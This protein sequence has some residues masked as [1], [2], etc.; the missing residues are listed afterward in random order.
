MREIQHKNNSSVLGDV[1]VLTPVSLSMRENATFEEWTAA[2]EHLR[3][4]ESGILWWIGDWWHYGDHKYGERK[5]Q[6]FDPESDRNRFQT[7]ADAGWVSGKIETSRRH[8]VLSW[9]HHREVAA[10][11]PPEQDEWLDRAEGEGWT[12]QELRR[13]VKDS[14]RGIIREQQA[15]EAKL[16]S[17]YSVVYADPPWSYSNS[18]FEGGAE[19]HYPT[20][21]TD[22]IAEMP[23]QDFLT[24]DAVLFMW[25]TNPLLED[26]IRVIERWDF[27]YKTNFVWV[28]DRGHFG[29]PGI[30]FGFY[31]SGRHELLL[32]ATRGSFLPEGDRPDSVIT[33]A[34]DKHSKKPVTVY[35]TIETMYPHGPYLELFARQSR[36]GWTAFGNEICDE[37]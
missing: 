15:L 34:K 7:Y 29:S 5:A 35:D 17:K 23:V 9:S 32:V 25:T 1:A 4:M 11:D 33:A 26:A 21:S 6:A 20:M 36:D 3:A 18:G 27:N 37:R 24:D 2:G 16:S 8:E 14:R 13:R 12:R 22:D 10:L 28:K 31:V 19:D 30:S